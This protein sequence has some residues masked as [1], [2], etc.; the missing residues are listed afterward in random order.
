MCLASNTC[1]IESMKLE[2]NFGE[3][4]LDPMPFLGVVD[5]LMYGVSILVAL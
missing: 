5:G 3:L 4:C 1:F 2:A